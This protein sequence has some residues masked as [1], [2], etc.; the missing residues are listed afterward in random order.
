[1]ARRSQGIRPSQ[2]ITTYGPG[3]LLEGVGGPRIICSLERSDV[4]KDTSIRYFEI[5]EPTLKQI[6]GGESRIFRLPTNAD[7]QK[8]EQEAIYRTDTF[9]KW[10]LCVRHGRLYRHQMPAKKTCP[11]CSAHR[12]EWLAHETA[13]MEA[14]SLV[15]ACPD[16]HLQ[17]VDWKYLVHRNSDCSNEV[18]E[19][20]AQGS[21]LRHVDISC[22][23]CRKSFNLGEQYLLDHHCS[24]RRPE[25]GE[26]VEC[27]AK[28]RILQRSSANLFAPQVLSSITLPQSSHPLTRY[29]QSDALV[30]LL[31]LLT[32]DQGVFE[33]KKL[34]Q[35]LPSVRNLGAEVKQA[36]EQA[37]D[38]DLRTAARQVLEQSAI[39]TVEEARNLEFCEL[40]RLVQEGL[41]HQSSTAALWS[42]TEFE[43]DP[44]LGRILPFGCFALRVTPLLRLRVVSVQRGYRRLGGSLVESRYVQNNQ[45]WYPGVELLGEGIF[46]SFAEPPP[47]GRGRAWE[48][49]RQLHQRI[50]VASHHPGFVWWHTLSHRLI[51]AVA[52]HSGYSSAA[53]RERVYCQGMDDGWDGGV[54]LYAVQPGGDGTLGGLIAMVERFEKI[55]TLA[56]EFLDNC[57]NDPFCGESPRQQQAIPEVASGPACFACSLLSETSCEHRNA[58]LDRILLC[59]SL[60]QP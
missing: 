45:S 19:W 15:L 7:L 27:K 34:R 8:P 58:S 14:V 42:A 57:S 29:L 13:R 2:F 28:A 12:D 35:Q 17:D 54:L 25:C 48:W 37:S 52:I 26:G 30:N 22:P 9:P 24:G 50:D 41:V 6:L 60:E 32:N 39:L 31:P 18:F 53:V 43:V 3:A 46:L 49:W 40:K 44:K 11:E 20:R 33:P 21:S 1:M 10:S 5:F 55:L 38:D 23:R 56:Q 16:G 36:L 51:R 4:F 47:S 59:D